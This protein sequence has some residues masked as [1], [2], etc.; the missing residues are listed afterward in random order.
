MAEVSVVQLVVL[1]L[2]LEE[3]SE[4]DS[5]FSFLGLEMSL[6]V[7]GKDSLGVRSS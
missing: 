1:Q 3:D 4:R 5:H 6:S 2:L 7:L